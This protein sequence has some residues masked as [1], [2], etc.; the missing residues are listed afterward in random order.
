MPREPYKPEK[1]K[2][3]LI[4]MDNQNINL[5]PGELLEKGQFPGRKK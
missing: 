5:A 3:A 2:T 4:L 1:D